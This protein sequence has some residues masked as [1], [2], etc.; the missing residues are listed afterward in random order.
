[1]EV[2]KRM[3]KFTPSALAIN[4]DGETQTSRYEHVVC[5]LVD[6]PISVDEYEMIAFNLFV[7]WK[8]YGNVQEYSFLIMSVYNIYY[9][10]LEYNRKD[11]FV[12]CI[13]VNW[14][15]E[16]GRIPYF[17]GRSFLED[18][19]SFFVSLSYDRTVSPRYFPTVC[20]D[21]VILTPHFPYIRPFFHM[22]YERKVMILGAKEDLVHDSKTYAT[23][24]SFYICNVG[25]FNVGDINVL[26]QKE[27]YIPFTGAQYYDILHENYGN[28]M[29]RF[30]DRFDKDV[31]VSL[32]NIKRDCSVGSC[33]YKNFSFSR[34]QISKLPSNYIKPGLES[35]YLKKTRTNNFF[36]NYGIGQ[37][38][39]QNRWIRDLNPK[40]ENYPD[41]IGLTE[42]EKINFYQQYSD[43][44]ADVHYL[45]SFSEMQMD[46]EAQD[47]YFQFVVGK[48]LK[49][50]INTLSFVDVDVY[51][52][53]VSS[54]CPIQIV[55]KG[56]SK[57]MR[58]CGIFSEDPSKYQ[59]DD[60]S[61]LAGYISSPPI[62]PDINSG[63]IN[64]N[65]ISRV[66]EYCRLS[67]IIN[68]PKLHVDNYSVTVKYGM[69]FIHHW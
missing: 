45:Y 9:L 31:G 10:V 27:I 56:M 35:L 13:Y 33:E 66:G 29:F 15:C 4:L 49:I 18:W 53:I 22:R 1:M 54:T 16:F 37:Y 6:L 21:G 19:H 5:N 38:N 28:K 3:K 39:I 24:G 30:K 41:L 47:P 11:G 46:F 52:Y 26:G 40:V 55:G 50:P 51:V 8:I 42:E 64:F 34:T 67:F 57:L 65:G 17:L 2:D 25:N 43:G 32:H 68:I 69:R 23:C 12:F 59:V 48:N 61:F 20:Y 58:I 44:I 14:E 63:T 60:I 36:V 62:V 7:P